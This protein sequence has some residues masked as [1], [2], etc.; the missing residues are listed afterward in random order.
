M[1]NDGMLKP[2]DSGDGKGLSVPYKV[3]LAILVALVLYTI[4]YGLLTG[5]LGGGGG[6]GEGG[7][8]TSVSQDGG[9]WTDE[10]IEYKL[11]VVDSGGF[12]RHDDPKIA[13]YARALDRADSSCPESRVRLA[14][15]AVAS[16]QQLDRNTTGH[17]ENA[18]S[19]LQAI[20]ASVSGSEELGVD[21]A[22]VAGLLVL[23][24][25]GGG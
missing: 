16:V 1:S 10:D 13:S 14:D 3:G 11:A 9:G 20:A 7:G 8:G 5:N 23:M 21:C 2:Y 24:I 4:G 12:V 22:E 17:S 19:M 18:L 25:M 6:S 15:I